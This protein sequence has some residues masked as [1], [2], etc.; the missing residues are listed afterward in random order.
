MNMERG[1]QEEEFTFDPNWKWKPDL[2]FDVEQ[3]DEEEEMDWEEEKGW[4]GDAAWNEEPD[5]EI[6]SVGLKV[7][8]VAVSVLRFA[9]ALFLILITCRFAVAYWLGY[10]ELGTI[11]ELVESRNWA[12]ALYLAAAGLLILFGLISTFWALSRK[13]RGN[14]RYDTGRG[15]FAF[16]CFGILSLSAGLASMIPYGGMILNA[17]KSFLLTVSD[18]YGTILPMCGGGILCCLVRKFL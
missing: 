15:L 3:G 5:G 9:T 8:D 13:K 10:S 18:C 16:L 2:G 14:R 7:K 4:D 17:G 1:R 12:L 11:G 6:F